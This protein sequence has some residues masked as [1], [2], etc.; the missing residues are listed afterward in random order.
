M[1]IHAQ[2]SLQKQNQNKKEPTSTAT[3]V[4]LSM[5]FVVLLA[6]KQQKQQQRTFHVQIATKMQ[7][8][9]SHRN[10]VIG[11]SANCNMGHDVAT[12]AKCSKHFWQK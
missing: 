5:Y 6:Y 3:T 11:V 4:L 1:R 10:T 12:C 9:P 7:E 8:L 2:S